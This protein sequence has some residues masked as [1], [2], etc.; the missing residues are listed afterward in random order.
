MTSW[1][2]MFHVCPALITTRV[3]LKILYLGFG[4]Y[5]YARFLKQR[6]PSFQ[7]LHCIRIFVISILIH[8]FAPPDLQIILKFLPPT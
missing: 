3:R 6:L 5:L 2:V 8:L 1:I 4:E 7:Q